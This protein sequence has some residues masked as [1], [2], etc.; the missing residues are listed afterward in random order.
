M[1]TRSMSHTKE[2]KA[3]I[4]YSPDPSTTTGKK[5]RNKRRKDTSALKKRPEHVV[6]DYKYVDLEG[7]G[8]LAVE[9]QPTN[10]KFYTE[11]PVLWKNALLQYH[12][13]LYQQNIHSQMPTFRPSENGDQMLVRGNYPHGS[14]EY[15]V[16]VFV[17]KSG[18]VLIQGRDFMDWIERDL[19]VIRALLEDDQTAINQSLN[20]SRQTVKTTPSSEAPIT[21]VPKPENMPTEQL[22]STPAYVDDSTISLPQLNLSSEDTVSTS[23]DNS[24]ISDPAVKARQDNLRD[25]NIFCEEVQ[26]MSDI[27]FIC[28]T[29][30][31]VDDTALDT[32]SGCDGCKASDLIITKL[33]EEL[34]KLENKI[35]ANEKSTRL[36]E[37]LLQTEASVKALIERNKVLELQIQ[38]RLPEMENNKKEPEKVELTRTE[39][40]L[41]KDYQKPRSKKNITRNKKT[42]KS[43]MIISSSMGRGVAHK[44][45]TVHDTN[46]IGMVHP[47]AKA[48]NLEESAKDMIS[49]Y[50][51]DTVTLMGGTNN[52]SCGERPRAVISK[53]EHLVR[54]C[55]QANPSTKIVVSGL[56]SRLD[57]PDL[58]N[59]I[60]TINAVLKRN[61]SNKD[62]TFMDNSNI[63]YAHLKR[64]GL[65]LNDSGT[66]QLASNINKLVLSNTHFHNGHQKI[67]R[68][69][70][71]IRSYA[72]LVKDN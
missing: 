7:S 29:S 39:T 1:N 9:G 43:S 22:I 38:D 40:C 67:H 54:K 52:L 58:N 16:T 68:D 51:P 70:P 3:L 37:T 14:S 71:H 49:T 63:T 55:R 13:G 72:Q 60:T 47:S 46:C 17:Y 25:L 20:E 50:K 56:I 21:P 24:L 64:D 6:I 36:K 8:I 15:L 23:R 44:M 28:D 19:K 30:S 33:N 48:E 5:I 11:R 66:S 26:E 42:P 31:R 2:N 45:R 53:I 69:E 27:D 12:M 41:Q 4:T 59:S 62:Y 32:F 34:A 65:H 10:A 35:Q 18:V 57:R 61:A